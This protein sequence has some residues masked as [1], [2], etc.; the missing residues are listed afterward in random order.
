MLFFQAAGSSYRR[1]PKS[2]PTSTSSSPTTYKFDH[3]F[4]VSDPVKYEQPG[5]E[6]VITANVVY[7]EKDDYHTTENATANQVE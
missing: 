5:T 1:F 6:R 7:L 2:N 3:E 4:F